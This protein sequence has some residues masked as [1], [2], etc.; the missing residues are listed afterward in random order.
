MRLVVLQLVF[1]VVVGVIV[2][3][4]GAWVLSQMKNTSDGVD[5]IFCV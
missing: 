5:T 4:F 3:A 2:A 1:G